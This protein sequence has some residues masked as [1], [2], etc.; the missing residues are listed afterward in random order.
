MKKKDLTDL[1]NKDL[2]ALKKLLTSK[3]GEAESAKVKMLSGQ[4]KNLKVFKNLKIE[5]AKIATIMK[6]KEI[7]EKMTKKEEIK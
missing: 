4:E 6:E 1:R 2:D 7:V 5:V 3:K